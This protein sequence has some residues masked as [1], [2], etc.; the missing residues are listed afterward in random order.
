M[1]DTLEYKILKYL[2]E[3]DNGEYLNIEHLENNKELLNTKISTFLKLKYISERVTPSFKKKYIE[4]LNPRYK[5]EFEGLKYFDSLKTPPIP[6]DRKIYLGLFIIFSLIG[7]Y[8]TYKTIFPDVSKSEHQILKS[9]FEI[10]KNK[11]DSIVK[12]N[13]IPKN[14]KSDSTLI[15]KNTKDLKTN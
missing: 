14:K 4:Y 10:L 9:D 3:N 13:S 12:P 7:S 5:I 15:S 6:K 8:G 2:K 1:K 11:Y